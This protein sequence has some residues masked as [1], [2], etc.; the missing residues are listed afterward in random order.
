MDLKLNA[1]RFTGKD[2]V[3]L[4]HL[5]R[6]AP[7]LAILH[8]SMNYT[9][10]NHVDTIVDLGCG[11]GKATTIWTDFANEVI[12]IEPSEEMLSIAKN[13]STNDKVQ[14]RVGYGNDTKL[15]SNSIDIVACSQA[16]HWMEPE[17]TLKE[18]N[19][20]LKEGGVF[21]IYDVIWPP[22]ANYDYEKAYNE[23]FEG[24]DELTAKLSEVIAHRW[25]KKD[26]IKHVGE[27]GFFRFS[28]ETYY[29]KHEAMQKDMYIEI[30]L[31]QGGLEALRKRGYSDEETGIKK[32]KEKINAID[33][34]AYEQMTYNYR[35]VFGIK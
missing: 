22:T 18:V 25:E 33:E 11:T 10:R 15:A 24:V 34:M 23:L 32:F 27:S 35:V 12:G 26:H 20:I 19:R 30:A 31:S 17:S 4:Y 8:Q 3:N 14:Y 6:P 7:P 28:K 1:E 29:H 13:Q 5:A 21:V 16:F 9:N 2:Y